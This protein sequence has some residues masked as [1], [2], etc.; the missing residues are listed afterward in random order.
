M[1]PNQTKRQKIFKKYEGRC[2]YCGEPSALLTLDHVNPEAKGGTWGLKNLNP[3]CYD[4]NQAKGDLSLEHFRREIVIRLDPNYAPRLNHKAK[5]AIS[6]LRP[7]G[8]VKVT[9]PLFW[10]NTLTK[11]QDPV[12]F[13][14]E[15]YESESAKKK[16]H[17][18]AVMALLAPRNDSK[19]R[20]C[21]MGGFGC[22]DERTSWK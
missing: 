7:G 3:A 8:V 18:A 5:R 10:L 6:R 13:H 1:K 9:Q 22:L 19:P 21:S 12:V 2:A 4:C 14:F 11:F 15:K 16:A 20:Y 17:L